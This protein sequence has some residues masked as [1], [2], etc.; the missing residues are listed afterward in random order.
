[1]QPDGV[2]QVGGGARPVSQRGARATQ[3]VVGF[4]EVGLE[5][6]RL[7]KPRDRL[8]GP[9]LR[10]EHASQVVMSFGQVGFQADG[11]FQVRDAFLRAT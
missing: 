5:M 11:L 7:D 2:G 1:L 10:G 6:N 3:A 9:P 8:L 4:G